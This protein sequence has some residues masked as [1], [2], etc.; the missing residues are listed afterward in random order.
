MLL[1]LML[2]QMINK[3]PAAL[4][5]VEHL[6]PA[7]TDQYSKFL[8]NGHLTRGTAQSFMVG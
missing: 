1:P 5:V 7:V 8:H 6:Q 4:R 2:D 3:R